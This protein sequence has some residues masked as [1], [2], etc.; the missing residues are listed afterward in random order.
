[1][2]VFLWLEFQLLLITFGLEWRSNL[3]SDQK[4]EC[5]TIKIVA[6]FR[7]AAVCCLLQLLH[8]EIE[9]DPTHTDWYILNSVVVGVLRFQSQP[10]TI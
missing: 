9:K 10:G 7:G 6:A 3:F 4:N 2:F 1:M 8:W 5:V